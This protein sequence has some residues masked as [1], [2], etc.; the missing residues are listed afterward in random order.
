MSA[1]PN[2][3]STNIRPNPSQGTL[4]VS[5]VLDD[6][7]Y[8]YVFHL[9]DGREHAVVTGI[10]VKLRSPDGPLP[11]PPAVLRELADRYA[12]LEMHA[13]AEAQALVRMWGEELHV[14][15]AY[16]HR[17]LTPEFLANV[18]AR[19]A[20]YKRQGLPPTATLAREMS[21]ST[22]TVKHWMRQAAAVNGRAL[23]RS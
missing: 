16:Q 23:V 13:L 14:R 8:A 21:V 15:P 11:I 6:S 2:R 22:S 17:K 19:H 20:E 10:G 7:P 1:R 12:Q 4:D 9:D 3:I 18:T 5:I